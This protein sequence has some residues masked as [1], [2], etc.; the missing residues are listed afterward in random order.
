MKEPKMTRK[1]ILFAIMGLL[2]MMVMPW[3]C[4]GDSA[5]VLPKG[6]FSLDTTYYNYFNINQ[7]F[8]ADG[9][10]EDLAIDFNKDLTSSVFPALAP[11]N[12]FVGGNASL[13]RAVVDFTFV[14]KKIEFG[15]YYGLTDKITVG[16]L[17]SCHA[18]NVMH[19]ICICLK[20]YKNF[21][22]TNVQ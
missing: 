12:P 22:K 18:S 4:H 11:L 17:V 15:F 10:A 9:K 1:V 14:V 3:V 21:N 5:E 2:V 19:V 6:I 20:P 16:V 13:G 7:R 8:N